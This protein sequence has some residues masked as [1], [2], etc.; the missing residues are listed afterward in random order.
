MQR[1]LHVGR[2]QPA[3]HAAVACGGRP[4]EVRPVCCI[5]GA[6]GGMGHVNRESLMRVAILPDVLYEAPI[7]PLIYG[8]FVEFLGDLIPGM[9]AEKVRDRAFEGEQPALY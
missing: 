4:H 1:A 3:L 6:G 5:A 7:S 2:A 9:R 8:D